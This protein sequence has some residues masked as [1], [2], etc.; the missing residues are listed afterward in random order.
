MG[1]AGV[2]VAFMMS[3]EKEAVSGLFFFFL[4]VRDLRDML[5]DIWI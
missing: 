4:S 3:Q 5:C 1:L 2:R